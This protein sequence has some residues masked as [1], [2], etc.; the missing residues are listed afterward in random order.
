MSFKNTIFLIGA[1]KNKHLHTE[2]LPP[3]ILVIDFGATFA[4]LQWDPMKGAEHYK[5]FMRVVETGKKV[6]FDK[7]KGETYKVEGLRATHTY[8][9]QGVCVNK[10]GVDGKLGKASAVLKGSL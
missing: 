3:T 10:W 1:L 7:V 8:S 9:F 5:I 6:T 2:C 4:T